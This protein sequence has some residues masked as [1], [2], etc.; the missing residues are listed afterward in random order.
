MCK[1]LGDNHRECTKEQFTR[2][3]ATKEDDGCGNKLYVG[4]MIQGLQGK[5]T[6]QFKKISQYSQGKARFQMKRQQRILRTG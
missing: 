2:A 3:R 5:Q 1:K 4:P 6:P